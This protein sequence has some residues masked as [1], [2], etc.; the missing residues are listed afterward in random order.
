LQ[1]AHARIT[2]V[3]DIFSERELEDERC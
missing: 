2:L 1:F 3:V